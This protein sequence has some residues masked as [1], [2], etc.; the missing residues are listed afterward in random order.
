MWS[1]ET[2]ISGQHCLAQTVWNVDKLLNFPGPQFPRALSIVV[3]IECGDADEGKLYTENPQTQAR[4][5]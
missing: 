1:Q 4:H 5:R 2:G 3:R